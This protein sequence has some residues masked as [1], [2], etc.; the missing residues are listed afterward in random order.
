MSQQQ[1][2]PPNTSTPAAGQTAPQPS[3]SQN[4]NPS[5]QQTTDEQLKQQ[6]KQRV[7]GVMAA[8]NTTTN[9]DAAPLSTSQK[10]Q[11]FFKSATDPWAYLL[12][13]AGAGIDQADNSFPEYGQGVEGYSKRFGA[14]YADYFTGN[15]FGNAVLTSLFHEDPRYFQKGTGSYPGRVLWAAS[16][17]VWCRRDRGTWGPNYANVLGNLIGASIS[18]TYYPAPNRTVAGT[19]ERGFTV[20]AQGIIGSEVIEFWPDIVRRH[21]RKLAEKQARQAAQKDGNGSSSGPNPN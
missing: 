12:S 15:F 9:R 7:L 14:N 5:Q 3:P 1:T 13:A 19:I 21:N 11:L 20:T 18:N 4:S 2:A 16:G 17:T 10:Y 6:E 8:F